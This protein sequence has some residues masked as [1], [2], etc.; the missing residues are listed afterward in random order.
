MAALIVWS[1]Q[2]LAKRLYPQEI[3]HALHT[4]DCD[5]YSNQTV[6]CNNARS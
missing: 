4:T 1:R 5:E 6:S 3:L 2:G